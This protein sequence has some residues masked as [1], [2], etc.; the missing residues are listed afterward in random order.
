MD[1]PI[2]EPDSPTTAAS[3]VAEDSAISSL[4]SEDGDV[5]I[6]ESDNFN[7]ILDQLSLSDVTQNEDEEA[8]EGFLSRNNSSAKDHKDNGHISD[9]DYLDDYITYSCD[10][11][12]DG[13]KSTKG[14]PFKRSKSPKTEQPKLSKNSADRRLSE[15]SVKQ[16]SKIKAMFRQL[17]WSKTSQHGSQ[18]DSSSSS[19][20]KKNTD[21]TN[22]KR[23]SS[24]IG[25][26][27]LN[28]GMSKKKGKAPGVP[29]MRINVESLP[30]TFQVRYMGSRSCTGVWGMEHVRAPIDSMIAHARTLNNHESLPLVKLTISEIGLDCAACPS[31][32]MRS[33]FS[34]L[35]LPIEY[36]SYGVQDCKYSR[37]FTCIQRKRAS[38][39]NK[40]VKEMS[41]R[42]G[43]MECHGY[44][45][46]SSLAAR[47]MA[48]SIALAFKIYTKTLNGQP[49]QF[50]LDLKSENHIAQIDSTK[51]VTK[52]TASSTK[53]ECEA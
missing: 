35:W 37:V 40:R 49:F 48:L 3:S 30:Q 23:R 4:T 5:S 46:Q 43:K 22:N 18:H 29:V 31:N 38:S 34:D 7:N 11:G 41:Y 42:G 13:T 19:E 16:P 24:S 32:G 36:V 39:K 15:P 6:S 10:N 27:I 20:S 9:E 21:K 53:S 12:T 45:C 17:S 51:A 28:I 1:K 2:D 44:M 52:S 47:K 14:G 26:N 50:G 25:E 33:G 8:D